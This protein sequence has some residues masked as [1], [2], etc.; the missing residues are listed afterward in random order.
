MPLYKYFSTVNS[1]ENVEIKANH[2]DTHGNFR[3]GHAETHLT[4]YQLKYL[5][6]LD[7]PI[8]TVDIQ[9]RSASKYLYQTVYI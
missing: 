7:I 3:G 4:F 8:S 5:F 2:R 9:L 6:E 1:T